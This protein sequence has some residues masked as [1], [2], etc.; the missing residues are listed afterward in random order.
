MV[1]LKSKIVSSK[2][3]VDLLEDELDEDDEKNENNEEG[4]GEED[5]KREKKHKWTKLL[6]NKKQ[7]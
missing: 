1:Q 3:E 5:V 7:I 6:G 4:G 2:Q